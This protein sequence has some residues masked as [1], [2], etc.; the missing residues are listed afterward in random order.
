MKI[1]KMLG[2][3][4]LLNYLVLFIVVMFICLDS[5]RDGVN[6]FGE[7]KAKSDLKLA[8]EY[9][10]EKIKGEWKEEGNE[11]YKGNTLI[12]KNY[13]L[14]DKIGELTGDTVTFFLSNKRVNTNVINENGERAINTLVCDEVKKEVLINGN[15]YT[16]EANVVGKKY[17][18][19][20]M[21]IK[22]KNNNII[23]IFYL[24]FR[25]IPSQNLFS[26]R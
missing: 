20:Y 16:G 7:Y 18:T 10:N 19:A 1:R 5:V 22:D 13:T 24:K 4:N 9:I 23:G 26:M 21:P 3:L 12:N 8:Y 2:I 14:V 11:L 15:I 6:T 25:R 17:Q